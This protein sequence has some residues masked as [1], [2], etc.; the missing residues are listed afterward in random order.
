M[1]KCRDSTN[2]CVVHIG[3]LSFNSNGVI[4][5]VSGSSR[6]GSIRENRQRGVHPLTRLL[7]GIRPCTR[8]F[9]P[10]H[11]TGEAFDK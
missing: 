11:D 2:L 6:F 3:R 9:N 8:S 4:E 10:T 7:S 1:D 5:K